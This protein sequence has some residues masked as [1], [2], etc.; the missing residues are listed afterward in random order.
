[1]MNLATDSCKTEQ[2]KNARV[3]DAYNEK[4]TYLENLLK[5]KKLTFSTLEIY[6]QAF[7]NEGIMELWAKNKTEKTYQLLTSY[8]ICQSSGILGPKRKEGDLQVP[9]GFYQ[10]NH[11]NPLS[12]FHLSLGISYPN[13]SDKV[14]ADKNRPGG[15]IY[16]HGSCVTIGCLPIT[17][18]KIKELYILAL[19]ARNNGQKAIQITIY[20]AK[21]TD[22]N[23]TMLKSATTDQNTLN[24]WE[25]LKT[26]FQRFEATKTSP[27]VQ[28]LPNGRHLIK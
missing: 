12:N 21:M 22:K 11:F 1:M 15:A 8:P 16:I 24:L 5:S 13:K 18:D 14:F 25:D 9:E 27:I 10:I 2:L 26:D 17:D 19:E 3:K 20:P 28:F 6:L 7:K 4:Q 23:F